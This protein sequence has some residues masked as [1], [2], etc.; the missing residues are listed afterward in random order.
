M[1]ENGF[2]MSADITNQHILH[3]LKYTMTITVLIY[4]KH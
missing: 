3:Q 1:Y 2:Q 4:V